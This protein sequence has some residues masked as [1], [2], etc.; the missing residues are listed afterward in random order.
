MATMFG[1]TTTLTIPT[2]KGKKKDK[3]HTEK[4][5][6]K[7]RKK[8]VLEGVREGWGLEQNKRTRRILTAG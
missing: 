4:K 7:K 2:M 1:A 5:K 8:G 3:S 6:K